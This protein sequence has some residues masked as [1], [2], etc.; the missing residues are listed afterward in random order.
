MPGDQFVA[1]LTAMVLVIGIGWST[2]SSSDRA[3][4]GVESVNEIDDR[5]NL[6]ATQVW[7]FRQEPLFGWGIGTFPTV[8]VYHHKQFSPEQPWIRGWGIASHENE[9]GILVELGLV[10]LAL[11]LGLLVLIWAR[12]VWAIRVADPDRA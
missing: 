3:A 6:I 2:F 9:L 5:L 12:A 7:A 1:V 11:W 8:N 4:G 10:G